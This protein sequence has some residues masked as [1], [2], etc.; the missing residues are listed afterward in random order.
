MTYTVAKKDLRAVCD[1]VFDV[2]CSTVEEVRE[3]LGIAEE[4]DAGSDWEA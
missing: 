1:G 2:N 4:E 3:H